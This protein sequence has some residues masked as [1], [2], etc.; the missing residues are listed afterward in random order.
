MKKCDKRNSH[1]SSKYHMIY[2]YSNNYRHPVTNTFTPLHYTCRHFTTHLNFNHL[3]FTI[4]SFGLTPFKLP[5][6]PF[7]L[8]SLNFTSLHFIALLD[9]FH[10]AY[11]PFTS[12]RL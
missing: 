12:P 4:L 2:I 9:S 10:H 11:I 8:T 7:H 6:A 3:H 5:T 1:I